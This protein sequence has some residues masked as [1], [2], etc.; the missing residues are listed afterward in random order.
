MA[1]SIS[2]SSRFRAIL[3]TVAVLSPFVLFFGWKLVSPC[4]TCEDG[5]SS[6]LVTFRTDLPVDSAFLA[7]GAV[8]IRETRMI[9]ADSVIQAE[10]HF[11]RLE[12]A[13]YG[14]CACIKSGPPTRSV[15]KDS[16]SLVVFSGAKSM[17]SRR[18]V[19][20]GDDEYARTDFGAMSGKDLLPATDA[21]RMRSLYDYNN[22]R[23]GN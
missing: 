10:A 18:K 22:S 6:L 19:F 2:R 7:S 23:P 17:R 13:L 14:G 9:K 21:F 3:L 4:F 8:L 20:V 15:L 1:L 5:Q 12:G 16:L 11:S